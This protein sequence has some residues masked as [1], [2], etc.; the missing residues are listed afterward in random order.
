M[1]MMMMKTNTKTMTMTVGRQGCW[2]VCTVHTALYVC[3]FLK[4]NSSDTFWFF[5]KIVYFNWI[6]ASN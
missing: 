1:K 5:H 2:Q 3:I 6:C 4:C